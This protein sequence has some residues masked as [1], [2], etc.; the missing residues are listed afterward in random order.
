MIP[1]ILY[2]YFVFDVEYRPLST[3]HAPVL[4]FLITRGI[5][6]FAIVLLRNGSSASIL[7]TDTL[8]LLI[9]FSPRFDNFVFD[10]PRSSPADL[11]PLHPSHL[12][13]NIGVNDVYV[14]VFH[15]AYHDAKGFE[16]A[17]Y[18]D[19]EHAVCSRRVVYLKDCLLG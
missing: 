9:P 18:G 12:F 6:T 19:T 11:Q 16:K 7:L 3:H 8:Y 14:E 4:S 10:Q 15:D 13:R 5:E 1:C 17:I 2:L